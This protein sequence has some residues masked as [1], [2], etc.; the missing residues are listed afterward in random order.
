MKINRNMSAVI[1]NNQLMRTEKRLTASQERLSSGFRINKASDNPAGMAIS[2]KMKAQI[3]ALDQAS[4]NVSNAI[5]T[6]QIADGAM[7]EVSSVLQRIRELSVQAANGT[8]SY[9]DRK[10]IQAEISA[11]REEIDRIS[12][13]TEYNT[14]TLFNGSSDTRVYANN[15]SRTYISDAVKP[16]TYQLTVNEVGEQAS[17][18]LT[19]PQ[20]VDGSIDLNGIQIDVTSD[21]TEDEFFEKFRN[22]TEACGYD[23]ERAGNSIT[24]KSN[25]FGSTGQLDIS[26]DSAIANAIGLTG[27]ENV[28]YDAKNDSYKATKNGKDAKISFNGD[29]TTAGFSETATISAEGNRVKVTDKD[30]FSIDFLLDENY[31]IG[32]N[33]DIEVTDIGPM[34]IQTGSNQYQTIEVR[35]PEVSVNSLYIDEVNVVSEQGASQ[36]IQIIDDAIAKSNEIRSRLGAYQN[37]MEYAQ[38]SLE[39]TN[40]NV[41]AAYSALLDT[42]MAE[43]MVEY[44]QQNIL[45]QAT[46]SVLSQANDLPQQVLSLLS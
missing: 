12:T 13:D 16:Q 30:G 29:P 4:S 8:N 19:I 10:S 9:D 17:M 21:M 42:D 45:D 6:I 38:L 14:K 40:E 36:A 41:T 25:V 23:V 18:S 37:R 39:E 7:N 20:G 44:T 11:L 46:I 28:E 2:N 31:P 1:A 5:S 15:I 34:T 33:L 32:E 43:E 35:I 3:D 24:V 27:Q 26:A 22:S